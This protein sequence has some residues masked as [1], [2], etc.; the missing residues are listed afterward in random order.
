P[1]SGEAATGDLA[2]QQQ[3]R[4]GDR[5]S[6]AECRARAASRPAG[7]ARRMGNRTS[8]GS[9]AR[10]PLPPGYPAYCRLQPGRQAA[11]HRSD[12]PGPVPLPRPAGQPGSGAAGAPQRRRTMAAGAD[13]GQR[14]DLL[15]ALDVWE[16]EPLVDPALAARCRLATPHIAGYSLDGKLRGTA[17]I[18]QAL[19]L[20]LDRPAS[21]A[22]EQLAPRSGAGQWQLEPGTPPDWAL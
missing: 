15:V 5:Q 20:F 18:Y 16:T 2:D 19:C 11:W 7:G 1:A 21:L 10:R 8:G 3:S 12:L 22:L 13:L 14:P 17:Q 4:P 6:G 9:G